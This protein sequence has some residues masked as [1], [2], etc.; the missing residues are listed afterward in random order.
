MQS[1]TGNLQPQLDYEEHDGNL[2][3]KRVSLASAPTIYVIADIAAGESVALN[4]N[5]TLNPS[6]NFIGL[7]SIANNV[8]MIEVRPAT[9]MVT[10]VS[11]MTTSPTL[12]LANV[13]R[14]GAYFYNDANVPLY[15]KYGSG[16]STNLFTVKI[17]SSGF[18]EMPTPVYSGGIEGTWDSQAGSVKITEIT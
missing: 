17:A 5:V 15:L 10:L 9:P 16:A 11:G 4:S 13:N 2:N 1:H 3:A 12:L 14:R 8:S 6:P 7:V 18:Y